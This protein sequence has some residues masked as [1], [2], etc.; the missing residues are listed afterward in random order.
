MN[1][2]SNFEIIYFPSSIVILCMSN[3]IIQSVAYDN[4][5]DF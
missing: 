5:D 2:I 4:Y 1:S 3:E